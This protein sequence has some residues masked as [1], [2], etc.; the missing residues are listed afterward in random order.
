MQPTALHGKSELSLRVLVQALDVRLFEVSIRRSPSTDFKFPDDPVLDFSF[1]I[2]GV[3]RV[4]LLL[5]NP[6]P[7][8]IVYFH[9]YL[10][11]C[12][13]LYGLLSLGSMACVSTM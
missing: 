8:I 3:C 1:Y 13:H 5:Y 12:N 2:F 11:L 4:H 10:T 6:V 9:I 7:A